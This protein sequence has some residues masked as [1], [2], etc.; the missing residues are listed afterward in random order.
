MKSTA[1]QINLYQSQFRKVRVRF[2]AV[3]VAQL[4]LLLGIGL[5]LVSWY[6]GQQLQPLRDQASAA[7]QRVVDLE[8]QLNSMRD[9][10]QAGNGELAQKNIAK[11]RET[12]VQKQQIL[13]NLGRQDEHQNRLFSTYF[14]GLARRTLDGLWLQRVDVAAGGESIRLSGYA[15]DAELL[16]RW[17]KTLQQ[18]SAFSGTKFRSARIVTAEDDKDVLQFSLHTDADTDSETEQ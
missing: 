18:E 13:S 1:Q 4:A 5:T 6:G 7:Q 14:E 2:S 8:S 11:L 12:R 3:R 16:P 17:I 10:H 9:L 15:T